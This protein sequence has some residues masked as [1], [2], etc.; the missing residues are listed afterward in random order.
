MKSV[1]AVLYG[2]MGVFVLFG[3]WFEWFELGSLSVDT[4]YMIAFILIATGSI[5]AFM[6]KGVKERDE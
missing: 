6:P 2:L 4:V 5:L 1:T 3:A